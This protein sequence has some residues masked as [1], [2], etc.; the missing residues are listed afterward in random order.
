MDFKLK[1]LINI[2]EMHII[3]PKKEPTVDKLV[4]KAIGKTVLTTNPLLIKK[5][6]E[7]KQAKGESDKLDNW[8]KDPK[9][10]E[11]LRNIL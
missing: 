5:L 1:D 7:W 3:K 6:V 9:K 4:S 8:L 10:I 2:R 11:E